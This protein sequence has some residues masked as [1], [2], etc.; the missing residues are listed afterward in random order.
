MK[1]EYAK[2]IRRLSDS[3]DLNK[4][5]LETHMQYTTF[6]IGVLTQNTAASDLYNGRG[7]VAEDNTSRFGLI[8][9]K[10]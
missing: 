10:I 4:K 1:K 7:G 6:C 9:Q 2:L 3:N 5:L 8:D